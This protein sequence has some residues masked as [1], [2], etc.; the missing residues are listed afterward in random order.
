[1]NGGNYG[2]SNQLRMFGMK[3]HLCFPHENVK[4]QIFRLFQGTWNNQNR[5]KKIRL[6]QSS[7]LQERD[8]NEVKTQNVLELQHCISPKWVELFSFFKRITPQISF[9]CLGHTNPPSADS[10]PSKDYSLISA[11]QTSNNG[12]S[13]IQ[14]WP[15]Q[16]F[17]PQIMASND[18]LSNI[19]ASDS[20]LK[21]WPLQHLSLK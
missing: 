2:C 14:W 18:G 4:W 7:R 15:L 21:Q 20:G 13:N 17:E 3:W 10:D 1:M 8:P 11:I 19:R 16:H 6:Y 12:L 5:L 9:T